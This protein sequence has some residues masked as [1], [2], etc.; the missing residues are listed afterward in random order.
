MITVLLIICAAQITIAQVAG[1]IA[2]NFGGSSKFNG[3]VYAI[4]TQADGKILVGGN[5]NSYNG[6][7]A[8]NIICLNADGTNDTSF[9][10]GTGFDN[11][12]YAIA[13]RADGKI[14]VGGDFTEYNGSF[15][16]AYLIGLHSRYSP[17][18]KISITGPGG[19]A[20]GATWGVDYFLTDAGGGIWTA[21]NIV[22]P[23]GSIKFR[24]NADWIINWGAASWPS[25]TGFQDVPNIPG[26]KGTYN[27]TFNQ[28]TGEYSFSK[29]LSIDTQ[30][31]NDKIVVFPNPTSSLLNLSVNDSIILNKVTIVDITGKVVIEQTENLSTI[32]VEQLAKGVYILTAYAGDK[33]YQEKFIKE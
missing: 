22:L 26:A 7:T 16:T 32:N 15:N 3:K 4:A 11:G 24:L 27:V 18:T 25:G 2:Q 6:A 17:L 1:D 12:I 23:G 20:P 14:L 33:K 28:N 30:V 5:F 10:T 31:I 8:N 13:T 21:N 9:I 29:S 19:P